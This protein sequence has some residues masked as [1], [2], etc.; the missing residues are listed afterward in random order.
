MHYEIDAY[1]PQEFSDDSINVHCV[2]SCRFG[3]K[4]E[5]TLIVNF[6][7]G[8]FFRSDSWNGDPRRIEQAV[9]ELQRVL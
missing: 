9:E 1:I 4:N 6:H 2:L 7:N 3:S 5:K 8:W